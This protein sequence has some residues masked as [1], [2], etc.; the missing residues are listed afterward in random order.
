M[1][2]SDGISDKC[3]IN[4]Q[5]WESGE[6]ERWGRVKRWKRADMEESKRGQKSKK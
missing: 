4:Q 6:F 2:I 5:F 1:A 3:K